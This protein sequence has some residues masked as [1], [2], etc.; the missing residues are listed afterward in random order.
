MLINSWNIQNSEQIFIWIWM[1]GL[2][3]KSN[4]TSKVN[5]KVILREQQSELFLRIRPNVIK[6][7][8]H[9]FLKT[10][11]NFQNLEMNIVFKRNRWW[12][13]SNWNTKNSTIFWRCYFYLTCWSNDNFVEN[14]DCF[15]P[16][17]NW[18]NQE[19]I[20]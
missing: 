4:S 8:V 16:T 3:K 1:T 20:T 17:I 13:Y 12:I 9:N 18:H 10:I 2:H 5:P 15:G 14:H 11:H 6:K 19:L 7:R